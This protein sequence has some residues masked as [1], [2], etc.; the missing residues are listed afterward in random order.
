MRLL[1]TGAA[2]YVGRHVTAAAL[3]AGHE[4][5]A[6]LRDPKRAEA[7]RADLGAA[8]TQLSVVGLDLLRPEGWERALQGIDAVL[9]TA[10]P[11][12]TRAPRS[13]AEIL[14]PA[15]DGTE[16]V[17]RESAAAGVA[18][19]VVTS[20]I[21][22]ILGA[23]GK[24]PGDTF[25][26]ADWTDPDAPDIR[27]YARAKTL[28]EQAARAIARE[29]DGLTLATVNPGYVFGPHLGGGVSSSLTLIDML[30]RGRMPLLPR[31]AFPSVDVRDVAAA[32]LAALTAPDEARLVAS[33]QTLWLPEI[34]RIVRSAVPKA[35][36][37]Q[38]VAP[39]WAVRLAARLSPSLGMIAGGVG[40]AKNTDPASCEHALGRP[41]AD[42]RPAV[43]E[44]ARALANETNNAARRARRGAYG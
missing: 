16:R 6:T 44:T 3:E 42:P 18:R 31:L 26:A 24:G 15:V 36:A 21:A 38:L 19:V 7:L 27:T 34:S 43:A 4:V 23:P 35:R 8:P 2:G 40:T 33:G 5:R 17:L 29:T 22:A 25:G 10:S 1:I 30:L 32:H 9:H 37:P 13:D 41:L 11:V 14:R 20:S 39:D 12:P 28:A